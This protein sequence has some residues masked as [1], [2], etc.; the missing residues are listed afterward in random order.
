RGPA[1]V[2]RLYRPADAVGGRTGGDAAG[3]AVASVA[4]ATGAIAA[5][6]VDA[7]PARAVTARGARSAKAAAPVGGAAAGAEGPRPHAP[8][9]P[10]GVGVEAGIGDERRTRAVACHAW[11]QLLLRLR[12]Q[13]NG[14]HVLDGS[15]VADPSAVDVSLAVPWV[16]PHHPGVHA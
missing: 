6:G 5:D 14:H 4:R 11:R 7:L 9:L 10:G 1:D 8:R 13:R 3:L 12:R 15:G 16:A 2:A